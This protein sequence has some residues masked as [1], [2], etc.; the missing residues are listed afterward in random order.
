METWVMHF[1]RLGPIIIGTMDINKSRKFYENVFGIRI[2]EESENYL[3]AYME[4]GTHIE[5]E[6]DSPERFPYWAERNVGTFKN[7]Q[8]LVNDIDAFLEIVSMNGGKIV[9][10]K[11]ARKWGGYGAEF[12][13]VDGNI[14]LIAQPE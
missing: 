2:D 7:S 12:S 6:E 1:P 10:S 8:F 11:T 5:I 4:D 14:F 13:D 3:S 9:T